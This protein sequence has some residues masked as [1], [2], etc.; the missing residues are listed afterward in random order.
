VICVV[1]GLQAWVSLLTSE[2]T[3]VCLQTIDFFFS[4]NASFL[5]VYV[6]ALCMHLIVENSL[7]LSR[8]CQQL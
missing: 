2:L 4:S 5:G 3:M 7:V 1:L 8:A 6:I